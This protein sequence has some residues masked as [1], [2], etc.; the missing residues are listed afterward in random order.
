MLA[1]LRHILLG[2]PLSTTVIK[3]ERLTNAQ[4]LAVLASDPLSSTA[5]ATEEILIALASGGTALAFFSLPVAVVIAGLILLVSYSYRQVIHAYPQ[6]G[7]V[8]NVA[9]QNLGE[10]AA[11]TGAA[12]LLI[13]YVLTTAVSTAAG[14]AALTSAFPFLFT[15]RVPIG[16]AVIVF[17]MWM[18]LRGVRESGRIFAIPTYIFIVSFAIMI[19]YGLWRYFS[20]GIGDPISFMRLNAK[21]AALPTGLFL[22]VRAFAAGCTAMT[23]IEAVSNGVQVFKPPEPENAAKTLM[24][25]ALILIS[26]FLGVTF[27]AYIL[28]IAPSPDETVISQ[29]ARN[30]F[31][32]GPLYFL[33]QGGTMLILLLAANTPFAGFPR[34]A[35]QLAKDEYFPKQFANLGSRLVFANGIMA[36]SFIASFLVWFF[37]G[38][39]HALIPLYAVGVFLSFS[40]S[41]LGMIFHWRRKDGRRWKEMGLNAVGCLATTV[42]FIVVLFSKFIQGAWIILPALILLV[43]FMK[44]IKSHYTM[45]ERQLA[46]DESPF[47]KI[48]ADK[49]MILL[50]S[51]VDRGALHALHFMQLFRPAH[52]R[53]VHVAFD[54]AAGEAFKNAWAEHA[55]SVPLDLIYSEYRD[56][57]HPI[58]NHLKQL[59]KKWSNDMLIVVIPQ[60]VPERFWQHFLHNQ[61]ALR[62]RLEIEHDPELDVEILEI[63]IKT[64]TKLRA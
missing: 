56:I 54:P 29:I 38:N 31:G 44:T 34:V 51:R 45:I 21:D 48:P 37:D 36:L 39:V 17:L 19:G 33:V 57:I 15:H 18:N 55:G 11:L 58:L 24:R 3:R 12:S 64:R 47:P 23:G 8:Y 14:V 9:R 60:F 1:R 42:V 50:V 2:A 32:A 6:G 59:Q 27:L 62:L 52:I 61:T 13:D 41:Q 10:T 40:I 16:I 46:L 26:I 20:G 49:T 30:L 63:P 35:Y 25:M 4:G 22:L 53:A 5:Y 28:K 43:G 7:G